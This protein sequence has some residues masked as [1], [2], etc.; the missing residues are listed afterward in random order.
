MVT[1]AGDSG[2][3]DEHEHE[4]QYTMKFKPLELVARQM[5]GCELGYAV[6]KQGGSK[7]LSMEVSIHPE[8]VRKMGWR[9]G[10]WLRLD[11]DREEGLGRFLPVQGR[12]RAARRLRLGNSGRGAW[13]L[14]YNGE[15]AEVFPLVSGMTDLEVCQLSASEGLIFLLPVLPAKKKGGAGK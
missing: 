2:Q 5:P 7:A 12:G 3:E 9:E 8:V 11:A 1:G 4:K 14:P 6:R 15:A 13:C 10:E